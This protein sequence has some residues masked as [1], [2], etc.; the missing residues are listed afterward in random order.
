M[1]AP[2]TL[3]GL[4][5]IAVL[6]IAAL[7][8]P[9]C[10]SAYRSQKAQSRVDNAQ[11]GAAEASGTDAIA[12]VSNR[13]ASSAASEDLTRA[14]AEDIQSAPGADV[15]ANS[16]VDLAGRKALCKR[17]AYINTPQCSRFAQEPTR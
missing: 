7:A 17:A 14:N 5:I 9:S 13:A 3:I 2:R 11:A 16:G 1:I 15:R 10:I 12:T 4:L 8:V 6:V